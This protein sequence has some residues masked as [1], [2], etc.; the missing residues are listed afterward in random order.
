MSRGLP[1]K[2]VQVK[3]TV[4]PPSRGLS[5][6]AAESWGTTVRKS[7]TSGTSMDWLNSLHIQLW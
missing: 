1:C 2:Q 5:F 4:P 7:P 6:N 3:T